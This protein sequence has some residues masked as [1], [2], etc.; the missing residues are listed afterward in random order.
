VVFVYKPFDIITLDLHP[1]RV[2]FPKRLSNLDGSGGGRERGGEV[3]IE[4]EKRRRR[5]PSDRSLVW[6][7]D[8][9]ENL[10]SV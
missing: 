6:T 2:T 10:F 4:P 7:T 3:N 5:F 9:K 8:K 1:I